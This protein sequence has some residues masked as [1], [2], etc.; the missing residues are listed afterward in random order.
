MEDEDLRLEA[1]ERLLADDPV[2]LLLSPSSSLRSFRPPLRS[3]SRRFLLV[4]L[5]SCS[6][7]LSESLL[8]SFSLLLLDS[9]AMFFLLRCLLSSSESSSLDSL[10]DSLPL[11]LELED[12]EDVR[13]SLQLRSLPS[14]LRSFSACFRALSLLNRSL[15]RSS[16]SF[17]IYT[18]HLKEMW[19]LDEPGC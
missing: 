8:F 13:E 2:T 7:L 15:S 11:L 1:F 12:D 5:R 19:L 17:S 4:S 10:D 16:F 6:C 14:L 9:D 18:V 3:S